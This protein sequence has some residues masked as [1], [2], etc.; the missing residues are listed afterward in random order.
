MA[1]GTIGARAFG[2]AYTMQFEASAEGN[3]NHIRHV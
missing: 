2:L 1:V 3:P